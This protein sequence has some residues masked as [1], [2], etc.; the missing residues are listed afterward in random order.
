MTVQPPIGVAVLS[1]ISENITDINTRHIGGERVLYR[2]HRALQPYWCFKVRLIAAC[3]F[4][5]F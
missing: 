1:V 4:V 2:L 5:F 3:F